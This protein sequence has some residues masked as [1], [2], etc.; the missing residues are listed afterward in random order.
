MSTPPDPRRLPAFIPGGGRAVNVVVETA[1]GS[2]N[3]FA[4]DEEAHLF[5]LKKVLPEGMAFPYDF[6]FVPST[7][8]GDGDPLDVLV[9][10]DEPAFA[11]CLI[12]C[13]VVGAI[14]GDQWE[15]RKRGARPV[16]NDRIVAVALASRT[17]EDLRAL[18]DLNA[19]MLGQVEAFF[20]HYH[21]TM[22]RRYRVRGRRGP[23]EA[24][25]LVERSARAWRAS[26]DVGRSK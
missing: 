22:G 11:G 9:L 6:G 16:R 12:G 10:M 17:H 5:R 8:A 23:R 1:R 18:D 13:R 3:K 14:L 2:R 21:A 25:R 20:V 26:P 15:S 7:L 4:W 24:W 19:S